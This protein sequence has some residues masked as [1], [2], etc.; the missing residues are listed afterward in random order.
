MNLS[1]KENILKITRFKQM[2][3]FKRFYGSN[4]DHVILNTKFQ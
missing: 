4:N 3:K 1:S 2:K